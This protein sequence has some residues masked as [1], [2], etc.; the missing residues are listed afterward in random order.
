MSSER[1]SQSFAFTVNLNQGRIQKIQKEGAEFAARAD[2]REERGRGGGG[3]EE[4]LPGLFPETI[5]VN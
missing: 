4:V 5:I 3:E 1:C 2:N